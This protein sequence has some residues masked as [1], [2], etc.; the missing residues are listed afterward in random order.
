MPCYSPL[1]AYRSRTRTKRGKHGITFDR[2]ASNGQEVSLPCGQCSGC[3]QKRARDWAIRCMHEAS[4]HASNFFV[5]LTYDDEH[6][7]LIN[8]YPTLNHRDFQLFMKRLRKKTGQKLR[9]YMCG[10]YGPKTKRPH[11]HAIIFGLE[12][13][14]LVLFSEHENG[15]RLYTSKTLAKAWGH[16]HVLAGGVEYSSARYVAGY[17]HKKR[18]GPDAERHYSFTD[19][20]TGE[21]TCVEPEYSCMSRRPGIATTWWEEWKDETMDHDH[22]VVRGQKY[23]LPKFYDRKIEE[24]DEKFYE[25]L[26]TLRQ[27]EIGERWENKSD[28]ELARIGRVK[29]NLEKRRIERQKL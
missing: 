24:E 28:E 10:E 15:Q 19:P 9:Y 4:S 8:G 27:M 20:E 11:Y 13:V 18:L 25:Y 3:R 12:L 22:V 23:P 17:I 29:R 14:D 2:K 1:K 7:P 26:K 6:L 16:G 21:I 5:T